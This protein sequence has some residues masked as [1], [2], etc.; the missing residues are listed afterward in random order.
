[1]GNN[2]FGADLLGGAEGMGFNSGPDIIASL[3][4]IQRIMAQQND[5]AGFEMPLG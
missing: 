4:Q 2:M 5:P 1:M 3:E